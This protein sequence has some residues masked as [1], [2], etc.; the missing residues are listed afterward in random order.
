MPPRLA[1]LVSRGPDEGA[2]I[3]LGDEVRIVGR[4]RDADLVLSDLSVSRR[5]LDVQVVDGGVRI[6][7]LPETA[8]FVRD[9]VAVRETTL[10]AGEAVTVGTT[11]LSVVPQVVTDA[12]PLPRV[13]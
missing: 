9:Q 12:T 4:A 5:H 2:R 3:D 13:E 6:R 8:P 7:A 1:L 10:V 11:V